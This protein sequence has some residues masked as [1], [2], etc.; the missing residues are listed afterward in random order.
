MNTS[1]T[2]TLTVHNPVAVK[3]PLFVASAKRPGDLNGKTVGLIWN[4]KPGGN[5]ALQLVEEQLAARFPQ[6]KFWRSNWESYPF[7]DE[8]L[9]EIRRRCD[10]AVATTGD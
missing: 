5:H 3:A 2:D 7:T 1:P 4:G 10:V 9:G 6:A 8:Q